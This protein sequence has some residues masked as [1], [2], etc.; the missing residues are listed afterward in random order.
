[1][2]EHRLAATLCDARGRTGMSLR[3]VERATG[4]RNAHLSQLETGT[5]AR[6]DPALLW[7]LAE[8]YGLDFGE[9]VRLAGHCDGAGEGS[10]T[11]ALR[12]IGELT[13]E[14]RAE[15]MRY[16]TELKRRRDG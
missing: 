2:T 10:F 3:D 7:S 11:V 16:V 13:Q 6:P 8:L 12:A 4:I 1:M 14:E 15:V 9:L 5:I